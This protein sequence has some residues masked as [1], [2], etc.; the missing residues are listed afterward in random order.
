MKI[1]KILLC[2]AFIIVLSAC[3]GKKHEIEYPDDEPTTPEKGDVG[4][5]CIKN[6]DCKEG[7]F[8]IDKVCSEPSGQDDSDT[9]PDDDTDTGINDDDTDTEPTDDSDTDTEPT[10]TPDTD[11]TDTNVPDEDEDSDHD[12]D[13]EP[14]DDSDTAPYTTECGNGIVEMGE[15]CD[16]GFAN[17]DEPGDYNSTCRTNCR[18]ARCGDGIMDNTETCDD[19]NRLNG[20]YC[21]D[22]CSKITGS[23]GDGKIQSNEECDPGD[24]PYCNDDCMTITGSCGDGIKQ[25]FEACD[26]AEPGEGGGEGIGSHYCS[27]DCLTIT[28]WCGDGIRQVEAEECDDGTGEN[29]NGTYGHCNT[30][31]TAVIGCGDGIRQS[32]YEACDD[33]N[34]ENGDYCSADCQTSY[35]SCGD[36]TK[37]GFEA[38]DKAE[39]GVGDRQGIGAYCSDD[40]KQILGSCGDSIKQANEECDE[41]EGKNGNMVCPYGPIVRCKVC[42]ADCRE[43]DSPARYCGD[44]TRQANE[45]CD[46]GNENDGDYCSSDCQAVTGRCGDGIKQTNEACDDG[47][48]L[49]GDYCSADCK[50]ITGKCGDS[51]KQNNEECDNGNNNGTVTDCDYGLKNCKVCNSECKE[52]DGTP[53]FCGDQR[54]DEA[55][56]ENCDD[57]ELNGSYN[58]C[59]DD[60]SGIG[61]HCGDNVVNG[62]EECDNG[63]GENGNGKV[64]D[65]AYGEESCKVCTS[66]C[67]ETDGNTSYCGDG[68]TDGDNGEECD[69]ANDPYCSDDCKA[70]TGS[71]GDGTKQNNEACD[72][73][74]TIDGDYCSADCQTITGSCGDGTKQINE[75]CDDED[76]NGKYKPT[77]PPYCNGDCNGYG[78]WCN[79]GRIQRPDCTG[80]ENCDQ[81]DD[82]T[83]Q[84]DEGDNNGKIN[85]EYGETSCTVCNS[86]CQI[87]DGETSYCGDGKHDP[88]HES[89]DKAEPGY[90]QG[91]G[92]GAYCAFNCKS[93]I[94]WCGDGTKQNN[95]ACDDGNIN[96]GDYCSYD[97]QTIT[98]SCGDGKRQLNEVC[99]N[100]DPSVG[101]GEGIGNYCSFDCQQSY[102]YCGDGIKQDNEECDDGN[103]EDNDYCSADC[104]AVTGYCGD[105]YQQGNEACDDGNTEDG[106]YCSADC[107]TVTGY[108]GDGTKQDNET[109]DDG[110]GVDGNGTYGHCNDN[111]DGYMPKCGDSNI[112]T[113]YGEKCDDG[114]GADGNGTYGH[115][116]ADCQYIMKCGDGHK[117]GNEICD[118]GDDNGKYNKCKKNCS[119]KTGW[120]GDGILQKAD[121]G[122]NPRC[123]QL[124][125][126]DEECD[127][128]SQN[129][130]P[131]CAYGEASCTVCT[132][133]CTPEPGKTAYCGDKKIQREDCGSLPLCDENTTEDCC[134]VF[135]GINENC[136]DG[137]ENGHFGKCDETCTETVTWRCG[138]GNIDYDHGETCDD[139]E[140]A[141][142]NG[143]PHHCNSTCDG[144]APYCGDGI[145]Q[146]EDCGSRPLCEDG[147]TENCCK[148][149]TGM[150]EACDDGDMNDAQG[151]CYSNCSGYCGDSRTQ[152]EDCG[153]RPLCDENTTENCCE[154]VVGTN[155]DCDEG[156]GVN[157]TIG[158]CNSKCS[159]QTPECGNGVPEEGEAC[160]DG[161]NNGAYGKC[162]SFCKGDKTEGGYCGDGKLQ[163]A[164]DSDCGSWTR[165]DE[166]ITENCCEVKRFAAG[167]SSETCDEGDGNGYHGHCNLTCDGN[168]SCGDGE[169]GND[170]ICDGP[171][172]M[173]ATLQ[174]SDFGQF[175]F[176]DP[177]IVVDECNSSC[178]P[179]LDDCEYNNS[180]SSPYFETGQTLC[181]DDSG[182]IITPCPAAGDPF[183]GQ[184]PDFEYM[185]HDFETINGEIIHDKNTG[186]MWE[187]S[188]L[189]EYGVEK[190]GVIAYYYCEDQSVCTKEEA[191]NYCNNLTTGFYFNWRLPTAAEFS[192]IM[193]YTSPTHIYSGFTNTHG[194]YI[195]SDGIVF[196]TTD[197]TSA[198]ATKA[199]IKCVRSDD[200][201][202]GN[203]TALQC[204][205]TDRTF[206][207]DSPGMVITVN[208]TL[209]DL[210]F[211]FWY[212]EDLYNGESWEDALDICYNA[213]KT[214]NPSNINRMRLPTVNE[215]ISIIDRTNAKSLISG[216]AGTAWTSTTVNTTPS[217]AYAV[218]FSTGSVVKASKS[219]NNI[220]ICIE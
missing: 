78:G 208:E 47:N 93:I 174:C 38:C 211:T 30:T 23:C 175:K 57:G 41:G 129:T 16:N 102:G 4:D 195:T 121:C 81:T 146:R 160:D 76:N 177:S 122:G 184:E 119:G 161:S 149:V 118:D 212:F 2:T 49:D 91:E 108:C 132:T 99:D 7:L 126:G 53:H 110:D 213:G 128:G 164:N 170:E 203:C 178:M 199:K 75:T 123:T 51:T 106:D 158:H 54:K 166:N 69:K 89:C 80:Y 74:N 25:P 189:D 185:E 136:D 197:G 205:G 10:D 35:G 26:N 198:P 98:G 62:D 97:C 171:G 34:N 6:G 181:Y 169:L 193:D 207:L 66:E 114:D 131:N 105:S 84:C 45:A 159:A 142:G 85:C 1:F 133:S 86:N 155:E 200:N 183:Y 64:T 36:G 37:Q 120:C 60:C 27:D 182:T 127:N 107:Q 201:S 90:G 191:V 168:S 180:Y 70:K 100:A 32:A 14:D 56:G 22:D 12:T 145:T 144:P 143:T 111:C 28:G 137:D 9:K 176:T 140:G 157:G 130:N 125:D 52:A 104:Q 172:T 152:R 95:E 65:C 31:C 15:E 210:S 162:D 18:F 21:N 163:V 179:V 46:D 92:I 8:C 20:D 167:D 5:P 219:S 44:G 24:D 73:G 151:Y 215:L 112:D 124:E 165:C 202:S 55:N 11:D 42:S 196:S 217:E 58:H 138:D 33:G 154:V 134:E 139:G 63:T 59:K 50:Q 190:E 141:D 214:S 82:G 13:T 87:R 19:G 67:K 40:C 72:D 147:L 109:C 61:E 173:A 187:L 186:L 43:I 68:V 206:V 153:T 194:S 117:N 94:G 77:Y 71:C 39:P 83:E 150:N 220:V 96:N 116:S 115:C 188:T 156:Y 113:D 216:F 135:E 79:D 204:I 17:S 29:G 48:T 88:L 192:T 103:T 218:D 101:E 3:S 148:V 209:D